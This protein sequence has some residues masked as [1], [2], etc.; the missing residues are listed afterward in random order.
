MAQSERG[1]A[2]IGS[3]SLASPEGSTAAIRSTKVP[4]VAGIVPVVGATVKVS[5]RDLFDVPVL[6]LA[7][8]IDACRYRCLS[9]SKKGGSYG[10]SDVN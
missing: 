4:S 3:T 1:R 8:F 2:T 7:L 5:P 10:G 9:L 6:G